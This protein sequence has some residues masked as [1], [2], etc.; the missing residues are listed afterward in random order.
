MTAELWF[1]VAGAIGVAFA[2]AGGLE[3]IRYRRQRRSEGMRVKMP[4]PTQAQED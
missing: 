2:I 1:V 4:R 3:H